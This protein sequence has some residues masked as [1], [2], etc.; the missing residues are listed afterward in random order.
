M[1]HIFPTVIYND[2]LVKFLQENVILLKVT[3]GDFFKKSC[4]KE[5]ISFDANVHTFE[6]TVK[7][8]NKKMTEYVK[9]EL[10]LRYRVKVK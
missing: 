2:K 3:Q 9:Y 8:T 7:Q 4:I 1:L 5:N 6:T 10:C